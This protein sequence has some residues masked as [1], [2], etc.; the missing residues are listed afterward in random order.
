M[1]KTFSSNIGALF[2]NEKQK[3]PKSPILTGTLDLLRLA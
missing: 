2:K 1:E 3:T